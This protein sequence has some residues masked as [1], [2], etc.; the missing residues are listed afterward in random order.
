MPTLLLILLRQAIESLQR[1][2][3]RVINRTMGKKVNS[4][5]IMN[6]F[7]PILMA[8]CMLIQR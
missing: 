7:N 4:R 8:H 3:K 2:G 6:I 1:S 5:I